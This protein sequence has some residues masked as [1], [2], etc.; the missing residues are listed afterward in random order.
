MNLLNLCKCTDEIFLSLERNKSRDVSDDYRIVFEPELCPDSIAIRQIP[1]HRLRVDA[2]MNNGD[3]IFRNLVVTDEHL[4]HAITIDDEAAGGIT[5]AK[6]VRK[7][8]A[9]T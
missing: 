3:F 5:V 8:A 2:K 6:R 4:L 7:I 9:Q 1:C